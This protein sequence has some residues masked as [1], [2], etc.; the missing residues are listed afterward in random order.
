LTKPAV[1]RAAF[2]DGTRHGDPAPRAWLEVLLAA[3]EQPVTLLVTPA[4][5]PRPE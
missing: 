1:E 4:D 2:L 3:H 5:A